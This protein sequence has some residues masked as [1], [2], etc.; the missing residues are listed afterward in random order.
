MAMHLSKQTHYAIQILVYCARAGDD[1]VT[2]AEIAQREDITDFNVAKVVPLLVKA[3]FVETI[4]GRTGG[5][6]LAQPAADIRIGDVVRATERARL[7]AAQRRR[8]TARSKSSGV[9]INQVVDDALEAFVSVLD[10]HTISDLAGT[11]RN[12]RLPRLQAGRK[13]RTK[14]PQKARRKAELVR[15]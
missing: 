9:P 15:A 6:V 10:Q 5:L 2:A 13:A 7:R 12:K 1:R 11:K 3:G 4:R 8:R 14:G